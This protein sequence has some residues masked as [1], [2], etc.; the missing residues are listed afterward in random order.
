MKAIIVF[1]EEE[2][3]YV[4]AWTEFEIDEVRYRV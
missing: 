1:N 3:E 2:E 4:I